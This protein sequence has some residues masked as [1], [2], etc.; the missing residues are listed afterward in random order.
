[1]C[2]PGVGGSIVHTELPSFMFTVC[3]LLTFPLSIN[4]RTER[5]R[6]RETLRRQRWTEMG[7]A[8]QRIRQACAQSQGKTGK[9]KS[10]QTHANIYKRTLL[11]TLFINV[12]FPSGL[13]G[14]HHTQ[15]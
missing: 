2:P 8:E 4:K 9:Y 14:S 1:M 3:F 15:T 6:K 11:Y 13:L 10:I 5:G 7:R 12:N